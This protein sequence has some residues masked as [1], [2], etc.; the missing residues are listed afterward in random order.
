MAAAGLVLL[1]V[2]WPDPTVAQAHTGLRSSTPSDQAVVGAPVAQVELLFAGTAAVQPVGDGFVVLD[3]SG[4]I[5]QPDSITS[6]DHLKWVLHFD[7]P[8][9]GGTVGV[10]WSVA[11]SDAHPIE[12]AFSFVAPSRRSTEQPEAVGG[13]GSGSQSSAPSSNTESTDVESFITVEPDNARFAGMTGMIGRSAGLLGAMLAI[14][15]IVFTAVVLRGDEQD[16]RSA[17]TWVRRGA[18]LVSFGAVFEL[19]SQ[20]AVINGDWM[21]IW[22]IATVRDVF[23]SSFGVAATMRLAGAALMVRTHWRV[24]PAFAAADPVQAVRQLVDVGAG[25]RPDRLSPPL[26]TGTAHEPNVHSADRA[27]KIDGDLRV[28][29]LGVAVTLLSYTFDGHTA[30]EG[31]RLITAIVDMV[32]VGAA[33]VWA[34]GLAMLVHVLWMRHRRGTESRALQLGVRFSVVAAGAL[35][36]AGA[37]GVLLTIIILDD[38]NQLWTTGWG[39]VL[40]LKTVV[41]GIA[42]AA[43]GYNH[44]VLIPEMARADA[45]DETANREFRRTVSLEAGA[46]VLAV[47]L[48]AILVGS[49][50]R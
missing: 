20:I 11:T 37:A 22:P 40:L 13:V 21:T 46:V 17:L 12:G 39:R 19:V 32:H 45:A 8:L 49:A 33:A 29:G 5:R 28:V 23:W 24:V 30:T 14:G 36:I 50:A 15:G 3:G 48:T 43:G 35:V 47:I 27:W 41:V 18:A 42:A 6:G 25:P 38:F 4:A 2:W 16:I 34:G 44:F 7:P 10:R 26:V 31:M 9:S 1:S